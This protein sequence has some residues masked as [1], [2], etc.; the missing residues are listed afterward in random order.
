MDSKPEITKVIA[1]GM[2]I[3]NGEV[4]AKRA[5]ILHGTGDTKRYF[6]RGK[7]GD[8]PDYSVPLTRSQHSTGETWVAGATLD[9]P[10]KYEFYLIDV[11]DG[12]AR[13]GASFKVTRT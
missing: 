6:M 3:K 9:H 5:L 1:D 4:T 13:V 2:V 10:G 8:E 11:T 7:R 12:D